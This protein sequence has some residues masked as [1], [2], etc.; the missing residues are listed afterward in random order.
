MPL[1][2]K[3]FYKAYNNITNNKKAVA[4]RGWYPPNMKLVEHPS[5]VPEPITQEAD[6]NVEDGLAGS[7]LDR[8]LRERSRSD[9]AKKAAEKRKSSSESI[10]EN[11]QLSHL[12]MTRCRHL[13]DVLYCRVLGPAGWLL[14]ERDCMVRGGAPYTFL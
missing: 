14:D 6:I 5:L 9:G 2:N 10:V 11:I 8:I 4:V 12:C 7:V 1:L 13:D 3:I